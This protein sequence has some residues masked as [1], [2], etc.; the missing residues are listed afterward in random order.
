M[1][2]GFTCSTFDFLHAGHIV[3]LEEAKTQCDYLIVG[4]QT[5]PTIDR[6]EKNKP[7][8]STLERW[9]QLRGCKYVDEIIPY[10]TEQDLVNLLLILKPDVRIIGSEYKERHFTGDELPIKIYY[11]Q[12]DHLFSSAELRNRL[13]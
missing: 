7:V 2:R 1:I 12:R 4:L 5:D 6:L 11:N 10:D 3:M 13:K 8:Q 9:I